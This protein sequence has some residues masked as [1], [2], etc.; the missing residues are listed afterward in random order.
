[1]RPIIR[2]Y[3]AHFDPQTHAY[4]EYRVFSSLAAR[5]ACVIGIVVE[6]AHHGRGSRTV[7]SCTIV[8]TIAGGEILRAGV[9]KARGSGA[10]S[11]PITT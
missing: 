9:V 1:M 4:A 11:A 7:V 2:D 6:L 3:A 8:I 10:D 5:Y